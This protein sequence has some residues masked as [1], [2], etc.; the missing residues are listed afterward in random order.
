MAAS[1]WID[2]HTPSV[3]VMDPRGLAVRSVAYY[4]HLLNPST[5]A[6]ITRHH[7]DNAGRQVV[8]W[9]P[10]LWGTAAHPNLVTTFNLSGK[11][12]L[13][14]SVDAGW[15]L[16]LPDQAGVIRSFWDGRGSQRHTEYDE[17]Q[18]P[19]LVSEHMQDELPRTAERFAYG[20]AADELA[21][22]NQCGHLIRHDHP[23]GSRGLC[24]YAVG[25]L[26]LSERSRFMR[27]LESVD[28]SS[29]FLDDL[30]EDEVFETTQQYGPLGEMHSQ[31]DA[32]GNGRTFMY[33]RIGQ[34]SGAWLKL[35]GSLD[36]P[37]LLVSDIRYDAFSKVASERAGSGVITIAQYAPEDGRLLQLL[38]CNGGPL[39]HLS[40]DYD[41]VG[42]ISSIEDKVELTRYFNNQRIDPI[43]R[44]RYD[45]LYQLVET[46]G[47]EVTTP[48]C[49]PAL[50]AWQSMPL[51]PTRLRN[52][53]QTFNYDTAGNLQTRH[54][55]HAATFE[56][57][58]SPRSNRSAAD[59]ESL[60]NGFDANGN[61]LALLRGQKMNWDIRN[62]LSRVTMVCRDDGPDDI[63]FYFYDSPGHRLRKVRVTESAART[64]RTDVRYL[65]GLEIHRDTAT[66]EERH[67][68]S[69]EA[70]R[71][72]VRALHWVSQLPS[73][74]ANDQLRYC[75]SDHLNSCTVELDERGAL[76][77]REFYYPFGG[78]ALWSGSSELEMKYKTVR[79]SGK[80]RDATGLYYYGYRYYAPW[81]QRWI[82][83]DPAEEVNGLNVYSFCGN[84]PVSRLDPSGLYWP[85]VGIAFGYGSIG[86]L[87][88]VGGEDAEGLRALVK[89]GYD[90]AIGSLNTVLAE[91]EFTKEESVP[92]LVL[93]RGLAVDSFGMDV[94][95]D[96]LISNLKGVSRSLEF[97][98]DNL[99]YSMLVERSSPAT[100]ISNA[101]GGAKK[102]YAGVRVVPFD[103][104]R[105]MA[106]SQ[107]ELMSAD[108]LH[109]A[110]LHAA[111]I[112]TL[113]AHEVMPFVRGY[114]MVMDGFSHQTQYELWVGSFDSEIASRA[115]GYLSGEVLK[116][117]FGSKS[118][119]GIEFAMAL[120][121]SR[122]TRF[123]MKD[124]G[125]ITN[126]VV[127]AFSA[128][129]RVS[130]RFDIV[131]GPATKS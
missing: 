77:S 129:R 115:R 104:S 51:D 41:P 128:L 118:Q 18:R 93:A 4:R 78:T 106:I 26:L 61:Q 91:L 90:N 16:N 116:H 53:T 39:Q 67:V 101:L 84:N 7:F 30:L 49:G 10:R 42:N 80:E 2:A 21:L 72:Q 45:S 89:S 108:T 20:G 34:L 8:S 6:R 131:E 57:F 112:D 95:Y 74:V 44:Y 36:A 25:S 110:L 9:D 22:H 98:R 62:Q 46:T 23:A 100:V 54:H 86:D 123:L 94:D 73:G 70:G 87:E 12:L 82:N 38:S 75:L 33:D 56:M 88:S 17:L 48:G 126:Y 99:Q 120:E 81:L 127:E 111:T 124:A 14:D 29:G 24:E 122:R 85:E 103:P 121:P 55:S 5:Q 40:Y 76:V 28:W 47:R 113:G 107:K 59:K 96:V 35:E 114:P 102:L 117:Y 15:Q 92:E 119:L 31:T 50:P 1:H 125:S 71:S 105:R 68:V 37:R 130:N 43:T 66:D 63:E 64:L 3:S 79:Y 69:V 83:P 32:M 97:Y 19:T 11:P 58:T 65:P 27:D 13:V 109:V 52:Y 60:A